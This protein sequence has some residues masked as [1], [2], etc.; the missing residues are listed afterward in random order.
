[1]GTILDTGKLIDDK[2]ALDGVIVSIII[3]GW[4]VVEILKRSLLHARAARQNPSR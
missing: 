1:M 2:L 3:V 4:L